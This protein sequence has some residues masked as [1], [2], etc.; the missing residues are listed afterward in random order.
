MTS[1]KDLLELNKAAINA[2]GPTLTNSE[3]HNK[4]KQFPYF[5]Y[6]NISIANCKNDFVMFSN[7]DE[8][9]ARNYF[10]N[11]ADAFE[12]TSLNLWCHLAKSAK[13]II[14]IGSYTGIYSLAAASSTTAKCLY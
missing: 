12:A 10:W 5:G 14:D 11:G 1:S 9:V 6:I 4:S 3:I 8:Y 13:G 2:V 7:N